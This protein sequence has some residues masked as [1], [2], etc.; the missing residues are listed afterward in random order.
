MAQSLVQQTKPVLYEGLIVILLGLIIIYNLTETDISFHGNYVGFLIAKCYPANHEKLCDDLRVHLGIPSDSQMQI[1]DAYWYEL[2]RQAA[3]VGITMFLIRISFSY[4]L[5]KAH[6]QKI[7]MSSFLMALL[8]GTVGYILFISGTLDSLY[9]VIQGQPIPDSLPW[10]NGSGIFIFSK[11]WTGDPI[12][13][14]ST[15][16]FLTNFVA[17]L[18][19]GTVLVL[20]MISF[21]E[22]KLKNAIA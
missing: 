1:G 12:N 6:V 5:H 3:F 8:Y 7:R 20:T 11:A 14:D 13:V 22:S 15:D 16:L 19:I 17:V 9:F 4:I 21:K 18:I 2:A 10:L